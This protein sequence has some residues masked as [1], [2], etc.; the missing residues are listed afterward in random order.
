MALFRLHFVWKTGFRSLSFESIGVLNSYFIHRYII[1]KYRSSS[2]FGKIRQLLWELWPFF[3]FISYNNGVRLLVFEKLL[4]SGLFLLESC[5]ASISAIRYRI[6][7]HISHDT[8]TSKP[9]PPPPPMYFSRS[10]IHLPK[11]NNKTCTTEVC[12]CEPSY[13]TSAFTLNKA[14]S[15]LGH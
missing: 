14:P 13:A 7:S 12:L 3:D 2:M 10:T 8:P 15:Y 6:S 9:P 5:M 1:I 4:V 11:E